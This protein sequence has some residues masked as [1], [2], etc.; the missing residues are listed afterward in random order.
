MHI[1]CKGNVQNNT[2]DDVEI[3]A[4]SFTNFVYERSLS[5]QETGAGQFVY[6]APYTRN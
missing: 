6:F 4:F 2:K 1:D 3:H 5:L